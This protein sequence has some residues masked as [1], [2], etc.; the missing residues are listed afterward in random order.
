MKTLNTQSPKWS[1]LVA[2]KLSQEI[3]ELSHGYEVEMKAL[4]QATPGSDAH[5]DHWSEA[6]VLLSWLRV[7]IDDLLAEMEKLEQTW[8]E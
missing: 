2:E 4:Q 8:P 3:Q 6:A 5:V 7:K 1:S